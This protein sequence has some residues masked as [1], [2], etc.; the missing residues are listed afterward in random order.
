MEAKDTAS[1]AIRE[2]NKSQNLKETEKIRN[3]L[4]NSLKN[5][6]FEFS[7]N[8]NILNNDNINKFNANSIKIGLNVF[9]PKFNEIGTILSLPNKSNEILVNI[10]NLKTKLKLNEIIA[11][12]TDKLPQKQKSTQINN[13]VGFSN[14]ILSKKLLISQMKLM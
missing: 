11:L 14:I 3:N 9:I 8:N 7:N 6:S 1:I 12:Q 13:N 4:N 5:I 10:G 2:I